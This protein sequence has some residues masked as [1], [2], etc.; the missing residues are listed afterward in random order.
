MLP[1]KIG[2]CP[3]SQYAAFHRIKRQALAK[4]A[5]AASAND[6]EIQ[7]R[8]AAVGGDSDAIQGENQAR[9]IN[10]EAGTGSIR[11]RRWETNMQRHKL[12]THAIARDMKETPASPSRKGVGEILREFNKG[13]RLLWSEIGLA[14]QTAA[15]KRAGY[16]L[17]FHEQR[18][19]R[20]VR[21]SYP[22][23]R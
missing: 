20:Q 1:S 4:S 9:K 16:S 2:A 14:R 13:L 3:T 5:A 7:A 11:A 19:L 12:G 15:R 17:T 8:M 22:Y 10:T 18:L 6:A 21:Q 23:G